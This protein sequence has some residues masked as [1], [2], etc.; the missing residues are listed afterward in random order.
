[1]IFWNGVISAE[2]NT[3]TLFY[4]FITEQY[5]Q[6]WDQQTISFYFFQI[7]FDISSLK[8]IDEINLETP[9]DIEQYQCQCQCNSNSGLHNREILPKQRRNIVNLPEDIL[10]YKYCKCCNGEILPKKWRNISSL[11]VEI[12]EYIFSFLGRDSLMDAVLVCRFW[13]EVWKFHSTTKL[14]W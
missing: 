6:I 13:N 8:M 5:P 9:E 2:A 4:P 3:E 1:M 10:Q 7:V 12:L 11:P 14:D